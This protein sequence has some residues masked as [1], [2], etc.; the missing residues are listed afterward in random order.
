MSVGMLVEFTDNPDF[1]RW[2]EENYPV[3][4]EEYSFQASDVLYTMGY[5]WY[6]E[7]LTRYA[8]D[9]KVSLT[10]I[11][12]HF[13][14]PIAYYF[15]QATRNYQNAHHR[16]DLLKSCWEAIVF[17]LFGLVVAEARHRQ[18][19]LKALG[20][21][22]AT[23]WSDRLNDKLTVTE[24]ILDHVTKNGIYFGCASLIPIS[25]LTAIKQLNRERN[26]FAHASAKTTAQQQELYATLYPLLERVLRQLIRL[27][28]VK[29]F[30]YHDAETPLW[31][32]CEIFNGYSL[33]GRKDLV[34]LRREN[35]IEILDHFDA[36]A[37]YAQVN[38]DAFC[39]SPF[40]HF[41]QETHDTNA[42]I[43][44]FKQKKRGAKYDFEIIN[45]SQNYSF[46]KRTFDDMENALKKLVV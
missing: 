14:A 33:D 3:E 38:G 22:W 23:L 4:I 44:F 39:L 24:N 1:N 27:E 8:A 34:Q 15:Y 32:R 5:D 12:N 10:R 26:G 41:Y 42:T 28:E 46:D 29:V 40:I 9:P 43:C 37:I 2:L 18:L 19:N 17:F 11:E 30:R 35:Y 45:R 13:P 7:A 21:K 6:L 36:S 16:L 20:I 25:T 31:P